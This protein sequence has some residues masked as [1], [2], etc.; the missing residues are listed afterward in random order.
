MPGRQ[1]GQLHTAKLHRLAI[2][3][4]QNSMPRPKAMA[5]Q[6]SGAGRRQREFVPSDM[7]GVRV[8]D[9]TARLTTTDINA[10]LSLRQK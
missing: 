8:R 6:S 9:K 10:H 5:I 1:G 3:H 7:I 4:F 2:R